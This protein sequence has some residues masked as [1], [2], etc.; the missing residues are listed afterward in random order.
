MSINSSLNVRT[1]WYEVSDTWHVSSTTSCPKLP[2]ILYTWYSISY[3]IS[4]P[5]CFVDRVKNS[6]FKQKP[7]II[8]S[9][10]FLYCLQ[11][12]VAFDEKLKNRRL[13]C[14]AAAM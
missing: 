10:G 3:S 13:C 6:S 9:Y 8:V 7:F 5:T 11:L 12:T 2:V 4:I 1:G 14:S